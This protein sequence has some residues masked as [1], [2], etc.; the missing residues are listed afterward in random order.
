MMRGLPLQMMW[1]YKC[2]SSLPGLGV[3]AD[4]AA[5]NVNFWITEDEANQIMEWIRARV[6]GASNG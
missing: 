3:H 6:T 4:E 5:V 1:G 2:E